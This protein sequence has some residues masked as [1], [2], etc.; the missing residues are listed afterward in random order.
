M[1]SKSK[2]STKAEQVYIRDLKRKGTFAK[3]DRGEAKMLSPQEYLEPV[4]RFL[5]PKP[6][7]AY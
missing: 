6:N 2:K 4:K 5:A 7:K 1:R 3:F